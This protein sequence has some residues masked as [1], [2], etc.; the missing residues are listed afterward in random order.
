MSYII[1]ATIA[2][3]GILNIITIWFFSRLMITSLINRV[4]QLD[5]TLAEA[6]QTVVG[7]GIGDNE[8]INPIQMMIAELIK[9]KIQASGN[10]PNIELLKDQSG[11]FV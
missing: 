1:I 6:L 9:D 2:F 10:K 8:P 7:S 4:N 3:F 11:K 5:S